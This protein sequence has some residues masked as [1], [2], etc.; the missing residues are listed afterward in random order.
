MEV[1]IWKQGKWENIGNYKRDVSLLEVLN[2]EMLKPDS[3]VRVFIDNESIY[4]PV[5]MRITRK[6]SKG[7]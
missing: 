7:D 6:G 5:N 4:F 2:N 3:L 1:Y